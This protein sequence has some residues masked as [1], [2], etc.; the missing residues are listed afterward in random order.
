MKTRG[1]W[2][3]GQREW[4]SEFLQRMSLSP[5]L[6]ASHNAHR[7]WKECW[8]LAKEKRDSQEVKLENAGN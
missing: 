6:R 3:K 5:P 2:Q 8:G 1:W 7:T 4:V